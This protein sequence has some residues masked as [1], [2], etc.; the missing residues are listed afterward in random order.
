MST[1]KNLLPNRRWQRFSR[2]CYIPICDYCHPQNWKIFLH[3]GFD[4]HFSNKL[5]LNSWYAYWPI[6]YLLW[7]SVS[8]SPLTIKKNIYFWLW[9]VLVLQAAFSNCA[10]LKLL[11]VVVPGLLIILVCLVV[12]HGLQVHEYSSCSSQ[13]LEHRLSN[14]GAEAYLLQGMWDLPGP[15]DEPRSPELAGGLPTT[16]PPGTFWQFLFN[17]FFFLFWCNWI[18]RNY[19]GLLNSMNMNYVNPLKHSIFS[20]NASYST[21]HRLQLVESVSA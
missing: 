1:C 17:C 20:I 5:S 3:C 13:T 21:K 8:L 15:G 11:F 6:M 2:I 7:R 18:I 14:C 16:E 10:E 12:E 4:V 19:S 9:W